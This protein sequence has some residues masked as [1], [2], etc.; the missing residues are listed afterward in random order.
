MT[1]EDIKLQYITPAVTSKWSR[2]KITMETPVTDGQI[3]LKGNIVF[4]KRPKKA[5]YILYLC[6]NHPIA[7]VEAKDNTHSI[8]HGLQQA[9]DYA[10]CWTYLLRSVLMET[11]LRST[12]SS[13]AWSG[14]SLCMSSLQRLS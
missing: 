1:E 12:T 7:I 9:M 10:K 14:S 5:D 8:S 6:E 13:L 4:R 11:A 2:R 3:S